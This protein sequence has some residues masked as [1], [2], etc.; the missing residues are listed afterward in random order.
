M[1]ESKRKENQ[2]IAA[3][4]RDLLFPDLQT[5]SPL[6]LKMLLLW[7]AEQLFDLNLRIFKLSAALNGQ[8]GDFPDY[9]ESHLFY[10]KLSRATKNNYLDFPQLL[11]ICAERK[12]I[13]LDEINTFVRKSRIDINIT[14]LQKSF[15]FAQGVL[16]IKI[17]EPHSLLLLASACSA[18][19]VLYR[20]INEPLQEDTLKAFIAIDHL[21]TA[22]SHEA[23][24]Y[25]TAKLEHKKR[26][27]NQETKKQQREQKEKF[28]TET[29]I[30]MIHNPEDRKVLEPLSLNKIAK[31]IQGKAMPVLRNIKTA[32]GKYVLT[33]TR[34][35]DKDGM[36]ILSGLDTDTIIDIMRNT[37][38][39]KFTFNPFKK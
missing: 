14:H 35:T 38:S 5:L 36:A 6:C 11:A 3:N 2:T 31:R 26:S 28:V 29:W 12:I 9:E 17:K 39:D 32:T 30:K 7:K 21:L 16:K 1:K 22:K 4:Q 23:I 27:K 19:S 15:E 18:V 34:K 20:I 25:W 37:K 13:T 33:R 10:S 24:G 8:F